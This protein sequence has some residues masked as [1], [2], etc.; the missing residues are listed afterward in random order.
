MASTTAVLGLGPMGAPIAR[1]LLRAGIPLQVWN[2]TRGTALPFADEGAEVRDELARI[3]AA[4]ILSV[5]PDVPHLRGNLTEE[6][7]EAWSRVRPLLVIM[8]TTS[9]AQV[10][11]LASD[12]APWGIR[13]ADAPMS[14]GDRGA[15]NATLS[16][17]VGAEERDFVELEPVLRP[18]GRTIVRFGGPGTGSL[19]KLANQVVVA[20]TLSAIG[21]AIALAERAEMD[22]KL[23]VQ[24]LE[25]GLASSAVL[26][27]K[28]EKLLDGDY[29]LGGSA[30][31]QLKDLVY[32]SDAAERLAAHAPLTR[33][34]REIFDEIVRSGEGEQDHSVVLEHF[35]RGAGRRSGASAAAGDEENHGR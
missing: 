11:E 13:V 31:N 1:N 2:R 9:P 15:R 17:M 14:G 22:P 12:L 20:G 35:R 5:L 19:A 34:L 33:M 32:A 3:D 27:L 26:S 10:E 16:L 8:S 21:E 25:G 4:V 30:A 28:K 7:L 29:S 24:V 6:V 23:L 18:L